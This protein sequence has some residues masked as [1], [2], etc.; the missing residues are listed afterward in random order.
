MIL[1]KSKIK[2]LIIVV[3]LFLTTYFV[4]RYIKNDINTNA[5]YTIGFVY[6][7]MEG[8]TSGEYIYYRYYVSGQVYENSNAY[9]SDH[10][11]K[12][13]QYYTV[14]YSTRN[15]EHSVLQQGFLITDTSEIKKAGFSLQKNKVN[16]FL[17]R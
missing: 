10:K 5:E 8:V 15:P 11:V 2:V 1:D 6:D 9:D 17:E 7:Y 4:S 16:Q 13:G 3:F 14:K 12:I